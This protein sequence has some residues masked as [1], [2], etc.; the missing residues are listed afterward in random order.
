L[1]EYAR[2]SFG[3]TIVNT[4]DAW[5]YLREAVVPEPPGVTKNF[6]R[7]LLQ[8]DKPGGMTQP[9]ERIDRQYRPGGSPDH[10]Y[11]YA[12]RRTDMASGNSAIYFDLDDRF[13]LAGPVDIKVEVLDNANAAWHLEYNTREIP[14]VAT[15]TVTNQNDGKTRTVT[16]TLE[17]A[18]FSNAL[19]HDM[20]FRIVC[21]GPEDVTVRWVRVVRHNLPE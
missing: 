3:K 5:A 10:M 4:P 12:A 8:R 7:W 16:F 17:N 13:R 18:K 1:S 2:L 19:E 21:D 6:E 11:D 9:A 14:A 20:D 15:P